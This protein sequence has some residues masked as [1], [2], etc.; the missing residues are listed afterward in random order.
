MPAAYRARGGDARANDGIRLL[1]AAQDDTG[2]MTASDW[3]DGLATGFDMLFARDP[4]HDQHS[5]RVRH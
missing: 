5:S 4:A 1:L 2:A 3:K